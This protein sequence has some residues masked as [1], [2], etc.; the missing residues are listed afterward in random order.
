L[1]ALELI[2]QS[3]SRHHWATDL[4]LVITLQCHPDH[5]VTEV[6]QASRWIQQ[7]RKPLWLPPTRWGWED[8]HVNRCHAWRK[9][10]L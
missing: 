10:G 7:P 4:T 9:N 2:S 6:V 5:Q 3:T 1:P 8:L